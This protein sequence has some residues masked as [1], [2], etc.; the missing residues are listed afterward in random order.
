MNALINIIGFSTPLWLKTWW[1]YMVALVSLI[2]IVITGYRMW[3]RNIE[4]RRKLLE[5]QLAE[6]TRD[7][8]KEISERQ[9]M[10]EAL[11]ESEERFKAQYKG[12]PIPTYTWQMQDEGW[13]LINY[14]AAAESATKGGVKQFV[15]QKAHVLYRDNP[16]IITDLTTCYK[17]R[18]M[19]RKEMKYQFRLT[20]EERALD[21]SYVFIPPDL[22]MVHTKDITEHKQTEKAWWESEK[23]FSTFMEYL[24]ANITIKDHESRFLFANRQMRELFDTETWIGKTA[25]EYFPPEIAERVLSTDRQVL[26]QGSIV[27]E[28]AVPI[29]TGEIR[30]LETRKFPI[31][32]EGRPDLIGIISLDITERKQAEEALRESEA[33][34]KGLLNAIPDMMFRLNREGIF[35][36]YK[37]E[38]SE[39]YTQSEPIIGKKAKDLLPSEFAN[40][41]EQYIHT[42]LEAGEMQMYEYQLPIPV[43]GVRDYEARMVVS[44][45]DEVTAI[46]RDITERKQVEKSLEQAKEE[47]EKA[48]QAKNEFLANMSHELRTPLNA[49]LG[50]AQ[51]LKR[52]QNLTEKQRNEI[53]TIHRSGEYLLTMINE[54]LDFSKIEARK[55]EL[56]MTVFHLSRFLK[57]IVD[58][59]QVQ[60]YRKGISFRSKIASDIPTHVRGDETRLRQ[61]LIN[62]LSNAIKF[63]EVGG[64]V[65]RVT[66][67]EVRG[68]SSEST[69]IPPQPATH[70][71]QP[72]T[73]IRFHVEDTGIGI[74]PEYIEG[75]F[76]PFQQMGDKRFYSQGIGLGLAISQR[77]VRMMGGDLYVK[78]TPGQ[79]STF[80]FDLELPE[81]EGVTAIATKLS[82]DIVGFK[83]PSTGS[84]RTAYKILIADDNDE[85]RTVLK[86]ML[87]P[88]GFKII[89]ATDGRDALD[90]VKQCHPD[91]ILMDLMMPDLNGFEATRQIRLLSELNDVIVFGI[92]A[93]VS[94]QIYEE[95][96][97]AGCDDFLTKPVDVGI[98]LECLQKHLKLEWIYEDVSESVGRH[99]QVEADGHHFQNSIHLSPVISPPEEELAILYDLVKS[100]DIS[101]LRERISKIADLDPKFVPF[102]DRLDQLAKAF[103]MNGMK[104]FLETYM[105][106]NT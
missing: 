29:K 99:L 50:Y 62:L 91:V 68:T 98:L 82:P 80:W 64:V 6:R 4:S 17:T 66:R 74:P 92:S 56:E 28:E 85:N 8:Q 58:I 19:I 5:S 22:V 42:V 41:V 47:A 30:M 31:R 97:A 27:F 45:K 77:F 90:N 71:P 72:A 89:E 3:M 73:R 52:D 54:I 9:Q 81:V 13:V 10:E 12:F 7:L 23:R 15:G 24:P 49:I 33:R 78:S 36:D 51:I 102:V 101:G 61:V 93:S 79:G 18:K 59:V 83:I 44:G 43:H 35:L 75:I 39:L 106:I 87:L 2:G 14:N 32:Q 53:D 60:A 88:L 46:V 100:G 26:E 34:A 105:E 103:E 70:I 86:D 84:G 57:N 40:L 48:N 67:C 25:R 69:V 11:R 65:F 94:S 63:T 21:V 16:E 55:I 95:S 104:R 1:F 76:Q 20:G 37:A 38:Q 96:I